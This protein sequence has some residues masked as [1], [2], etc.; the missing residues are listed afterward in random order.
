M[1][2]HVIMPVVVCACVWV[3]AARTV[4]YNATLYAHA[5]TRAYHLITQRKRCQ[6]MIRGS[7]NIWIVTVFHTHTHTE[8][9][10]SF[11]PN[12]DW[13][14]VSGND[15][16][17]KKHLHYSL[18]RSLSLTLSSTHTH[19]RT[20]TKS[21]FWPT[22]HCLSVELRAVNKCIAMRS[23]VKW[24]CWR[25]LQ[26]TVWMTEEQHFKKKLL[27]NSASLYKS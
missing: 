23:S 3:I 10:S 17:F 13:N 2:L 27:K 6:E 25:L 21:H 11:L 5:Q 8:L 22:K 24:T 20:H 7:T 18:L 4:Q 12:C 16:W 14:T 9:T 19:T 15:S 26:Q 1:V